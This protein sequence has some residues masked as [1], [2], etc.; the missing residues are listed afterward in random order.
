MQEHSALLARMSSVGL[1]MIREDFENELE[2][3]RRSMEWSA[4]KLRNYVDKFSG[5]LDNTKIDVSVVQTL[6]ET[7]VHQVECYTTKLEARAT[8]LAMLAD[9]YLE[10][11]RELGIE[12]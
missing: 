2:P 6:I 5:I 3:S 9:S 11:L 12:E 10:D 1:R 8:S 7:Y 4:H